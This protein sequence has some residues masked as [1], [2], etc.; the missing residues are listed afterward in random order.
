MVEP[1]IVIGVGFFIIMC[2]MVKFTGINN[3]PDIVDNTDNTDNTDDNIQNT[4]KQDVKYKGVQ[5]FDDID[6]VSINC[7]DVNIDV[8]IDTDIINHDL[9]FNNNDETS[10][11]IQQLMHLIEPIEDN[12]K[13]VSENNSNIFSE[14]FRILNFSAK[15]EKEIDL[16]GTTLISLRSIK[17]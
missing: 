3:I 14:T 7:I 4:L 17:Q 10:D 11:D 8:N 16:S 6:D 9:I 13:Q 2:M 12:I 1:I 5:N 15:H